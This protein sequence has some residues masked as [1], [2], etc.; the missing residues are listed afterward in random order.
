MSEPKI[1]LAQVLEKARSLP[2]SPE[3]ELAVMDFLELPDNEQKVVLFRAIVQL[4]AQMD[5]IIKRLS[6]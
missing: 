3:L 5:W 6:E 4:S 2:T 1:T